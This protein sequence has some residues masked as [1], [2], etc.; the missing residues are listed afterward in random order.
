MNIKKLL[1]F[2][3]ISILMF[4][5][6]SLAEVEPDLSN[7]DTMRKEEL[8]ETYKK[9]LKA[10]GLS[11]RNIKFWTVEELR[12][13]LKNNGIFQGSDESY[14][15]FVTYGK[16]QGSELTKEQI[17]ANTEKIMTI[18]LTKSEFDGLKTYKDKKALLDHLNGSDIVPSLKNYNKAEIAVNEDAAQ[19]DEFTPMQE[20]LVTTLAASTSNVIDAGVLYTSIDV[21]DYSTTSTCT[22]Q[23]GFDFEWTT[24]PQWVLVDGLGISHT[25]S[26][27]NLT[28]Y[29]SKGGYINH[30]ANQQ[31]TE[32]SLYTEYESYGVKT[33][34]IDLYLNDMQVFGRVYM[35]IGNSKSAVPKGAYFTIYGQYGHAKYAGSVSVSLGYGSI[36]LTPSGGSTVVKSSQVSKSNVL[37]Y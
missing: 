33:E 4:S 23:L 27:L 1:S 34:D 18:P 36:S 29:T 16:G 24:M 11:E 5:S 10:A 7:I 8:T 19:A 37:T 31:W 25:G 17:K 28:N 12:D 26:S 9:E 6:V 13:L 20:G 22:K 14:T 15:L 2:L 21:T 3:L 30:Y 32:E 35:K